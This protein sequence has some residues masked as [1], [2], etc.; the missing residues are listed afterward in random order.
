MSIKRALMAVLGLA[1]VGSVAG[2]KETPGVTATE[3][4]LGQ[5]MPYSGPAS[6]YA[7]IGRGEVAF[8]KMVND[9]G[10]I[11]GRKIDLQSLDDGYN[12]PK[13]VEQIKKLVENEGVAFIFNSLGTPS[14][15]AIQKYL[16]QK[17]VP[18]LFVATGADKWSEYKANPW[19]MGWQPSYR[20]EARIYAQYILKEKPA[21]KI[22]ILYQNDDFGKDYVIGMK[23]GL[24]DKYGKMV[25]K[26]ATYEVTDPT[27]D[28][29]VVTLQG[30]GCDTLVTAATPKFAAQVIRKV[31]DIGWKP[32]FFMTNVS[33]SIG[34][35]LTPA[36]L[37]KSTGIITGAYLKDPT[38]PTWK[39]DAGMNEW[40]EFMKKYLPE[41]DAND[42]NYVYAFG[43]A[44]TLMQV[45]KQCGNDLSRENVMKQAASISHL[46][47]S[48][49]LPGVEVNTSPTDFR[50]ISQ[51]QLAK[52]N[53]KTFE[54]FGEVLSGE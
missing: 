19:T 51:M 13:A 30:A 48:V 46:K 16:N 36:G 53:G 33:I 38:D 4:K 43:V 39:D 54:R 22:C 44:S 26:E 8:F 50:P 11:G 7:A 24:G 47:L 17:K 3:I 12:P 9:K 34:S 35:V 15:T 20:I 31:F 25:I 52:F 41:A 21:A 29:Q 1:L 28:S 2:A 18:Q 49:A 40:R 27:I 32:L 10:G 5:T 14:N 6:A 42:V 23:D 37:D 45:L